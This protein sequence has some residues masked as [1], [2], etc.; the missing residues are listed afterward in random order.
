MNSAFIDTIYS[1][2]EVRVV[3]GGKF[4]RKKKT[5]EQRQ[6]YARHRFV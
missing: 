4:L 1:R 2:P 3:A 5:H 6:I